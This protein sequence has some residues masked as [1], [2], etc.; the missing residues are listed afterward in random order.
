VAGELWLAGYFKGCFVG[1]SVRE[2]CAR[3]EDILLSEGNGR[4]ESKEMAVR[5]R[6]EKRGRAGSK[7]HTKKFRF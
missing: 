3:S 2:V 1:R 7:W 4:S 5:L 6:K